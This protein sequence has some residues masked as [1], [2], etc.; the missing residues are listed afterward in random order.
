MSCL[1]GISDT[2]VHI[3]VLIHY[4]IKYVHDLIPLK[5]DLWIYVPIFN[6]KVCSNTIT[7]GLKKI[8]VPYATGKR[9]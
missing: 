7:Q 3:E 6:L 8:I 5:Y 9:P 1:F 4:L 2:F